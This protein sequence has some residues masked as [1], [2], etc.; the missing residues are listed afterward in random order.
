MASTKRRNKKQPSDASEGDFE[1]FVRESLARLCKGQG[2]IIQDISKLKAKV[3]LNERAL[4]KISKQFTSLNQGFEELKGEFHDPKC[5]VDELEVSVQNNRELKH[6][7]FL[8][9]G[10][11]PEEN[12]LQ[13]NT[14]V[15]PRFSK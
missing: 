6:A 12:I 15:S 14:L 7:T 10:R 2:K 5:K 11:Q 4:D 3:Q 9:H 1:A 8:S 13:A